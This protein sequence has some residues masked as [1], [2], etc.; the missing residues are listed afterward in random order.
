MPTSQAS[1]TRTTAQANE[2]T[3]SEVCT[4]LARELRGPLSTVD[5]YLELLMNGGVGELTPEQKEFLGVVRR[6]IDRLSA[7]VSDW[8]DVARIESGLFQLAREAVDLEEMVDRAVAT[9]RPRVRA[10]EQQILVESPADLLLVPGDSR[11][12]LRVVD[13]LLSNAHK[14][15]PRGGTIRLAL[16]ADGGTARLDVTDTGIGIREE[17]Q[18][19]LFRKFYRSDLTETEPGTGLGLTLVKSLVEQHGGR[20]AVQSELGKGSIFTIWLP[21]SS[22]DDDALAAPGAAP[23]V[24]SLPIASAD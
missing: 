8:I 24:G 16:T 1:D 12:L 5:G 23:L 2:A 4:I 3:S 17:D 13:N 20:V 9:I 14:Y 10:K 21:T 18:D 7:V 15:T 11:A 22:S 19:R 6:N